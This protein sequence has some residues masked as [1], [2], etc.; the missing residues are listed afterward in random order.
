MKA[1]HPRNL[2]LLTL[3]SLVILSLAAPAGGVETVSVILLDGDV[4][5]DWPDSG[6]VAVHRT[7][8][9]GALP[10]NITIGGTAIAGQRADPRRRPGR[11]LQS[12]HRPAEHRSLANADRAAQ[13]DHT[14]VPAGRPPRPRR[15]AP[16]RL[17]VRD[18]HGA[19][20]YQ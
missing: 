9:V 2:S 13:V 19:E 17:P 18:P 20:P 7:G 8:T 10:V 1:S 16:C 12:S 14:H 6:V 15:E 4:R 11:Q 3:L 5:Q